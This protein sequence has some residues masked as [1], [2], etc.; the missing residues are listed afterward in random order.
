MI[1]LY[2]AGSCYGIFPTEEKKQEALLPFTSS[3]LFSS[4]PF[5][6]SFPR[7]FFYGCGPVSLAEVSLLK[8]KKKKVWGSKALW[9]SALIWSLVWPLKEDVQ[10]LDTVCSPEAP[11]RTPKL[12]FRFAHPSGFVDHC[13]RVCGRIRT[14]QCG[15]CP[16]YSPPPWKQA[17]SYYASCYSQITCIPKSRTQ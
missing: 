15:E 3:I 11:C 12:E 5:F 8:K 6:A 9:S 1:P 2:L 17:S 14:K 4:D 16:S 10:R 7:F 13:P